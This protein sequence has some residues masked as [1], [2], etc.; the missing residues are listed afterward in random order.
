[1]SGFKTLRD[2]VLNPL[3]ASINQALGITE[4]Y[5]DEAGASATAAAT[6][7]TNA[8]NSATA[9]ATS[10][11][12]AGNSATAAATS[13]TNAGNSA[14]A[15]ATSETNAGT[16]E[17]NAGNSATAAATSE[18]NAGTSETNAASSE[19]KASKWA[20][21]AED[22]PV[23][24]S[25]DR[26]SSLHYALKSEQFYDLIAGL[27]NFSGNWSALTGALTAGNVVF[28]NAEFWFLLE[29]LADVTTSEPS[30]ANTDWRLLTA[31]ILRQTLSAAAE[32]YTQADWTV[33]TGETT[34][35]IQHSGDIIV[36]LNESWLFDGGWSQSGEDL[37]I[38]QEL[39]STDLVAVVKL[40]ST[41]SAK[42]Q[43]LGS[44][45]GA[46]EIDLS[47]GDHVIA[48]PTGELTLTFTGGSTGFV[49][50]FDLYFTA[51]ETIN[52]PGTTLFAGGSAPSAST[53]PFR[54]VGS[55]DEDNIITIDGIIE[56]YATI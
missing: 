45:T 48:E 55:I 33:G 51:I 6:S 23:E 43:D 41:R 11:T 20:D 28:H 26:F 38:D 39:E 29:D 30:E 4:G 54:I 21:E 44:I 47:V 31:T 14:T 18:T 7:E 40:R 52:W 8:G 16:S 42:V 25:P 32:Y 22:V 12:N 27:S 35:D 19:T 49:L 3:I 53:A 34:I 24:T 56:G 5:R 13:E 1:M 46:V 36:G 50:G 10:E 37:I 15:A 2:T 9:A 17:T